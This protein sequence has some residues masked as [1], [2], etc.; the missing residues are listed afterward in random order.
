MALRAIAARRANPGGVS[1]FFDLIPFR[2]HLG[3][4]QLHGWPP[5]A[6]ISPPSLVHPGRADPRP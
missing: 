3:W 4:L 1:Q 2:L 6:D 5:D